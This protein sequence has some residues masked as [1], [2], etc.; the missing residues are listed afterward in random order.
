MKLVLNTALALALTATS[1]LALGTDGPAFSANEYA[2]EATAGERITID[3]PKF[4]SKRSGQEATDGMLQVSL[5]EGSDAISTAPG[6]AH[7]R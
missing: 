2:V 3:G 7:F 1:A 5:F 6:G 4:N